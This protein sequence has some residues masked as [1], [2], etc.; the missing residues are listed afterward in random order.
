M[1]PIIRHARE[2]DIE[3]ITEI[4]L[5]QWAPVFASYKNLIGEEL[6]EIWF[7]NQKEEKVQTVTKQALDSNHCIVTEIDGYVVGFAVFFYQT[8]ANG[9]KVGVLT[10]NAVDSDFGGR[11]LG[12]KQYEYIFDLMRKEGCVSV[13]VATGLDDAHAPARRA[14]EKAGFEKGIPQ[15]RYF[16]KL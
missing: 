7:K 13:S 3:R 8:A 4:T 12:T 14:Y 1:E 5:K 11:G 16:K 15:I 10:N 2:S 6:Y 9:D